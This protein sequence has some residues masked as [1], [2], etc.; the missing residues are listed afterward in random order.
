MGE[1]RKLWY[2]IGEVAEIVGVEPHVIRYWEQ[3]FRAVRPQKS[4]KGHRIYTKN[5]VEKL[6]KVRELL[7]EQKFTIE[8]AKQRLRQK[9]IEPVEHE[10]ASPSGQAALGERSREALTLVRAEARAALA[11]VDR[12]DTLLASTR[13]A[14]GA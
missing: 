5:D 8:G 3:Q 1:L 9:G 13:R 14:L 6:L 2:R 11:L 10:V 7:H 12:L 4:P